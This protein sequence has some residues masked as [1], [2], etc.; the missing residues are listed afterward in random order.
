[1]NSL[2]HI[3]LKQMNGVYDKEKDMLPSDKEKF[4]SIIELLQKV[5]MYICICIQMF[6]CICIHILIYTFIYIHI[7]I[8][9]CTYGKIHVS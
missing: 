1:M 6:I 7:S 3:H 5:Y 9:I 2:A 4:E 8:F